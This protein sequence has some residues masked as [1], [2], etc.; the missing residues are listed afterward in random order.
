MQYVYVRTYVK[1]K[2]AQWIH[3]ERWDNK[4][5]KNYYNS[6]MFHSKSFLLPKQYTNDT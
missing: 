3:I 5:D 2:S 4:N 6:S 1:C